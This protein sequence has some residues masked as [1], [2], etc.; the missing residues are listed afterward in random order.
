MRQLFI[1]TNTFVSRPCGNGQTLEHQEK[2]EM[3]FDVINS[4]TCARK[5]KS[6][7]WE[8]FSAF[9]FWNWMRFRN[10]KKTGISFFFFLLSF[11]LHCHPD[12]RWSVESHSLHQHFHRFVF[13][14][15][16]A[17]S[18]SLT[19]EINHNAGRVESMLPLKRK[20]CVTVI[21]L[22]K[23]SSGWTKL[24]RSLRVRQSVKL[25]WAVWRQLKISS[26]DVLF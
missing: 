4:L 6:L 22:S 11:A 9:L 20:N 21:I 10:I 17:V 18:L 7:C 2:T 3:G 14:L 26:W 1:V 19:Q 8:D 16:Q 24:T 12:F 13:M 25:I 5:V 15:P 23:L